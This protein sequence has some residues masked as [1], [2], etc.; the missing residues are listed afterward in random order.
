LFSSIAF[1]PPLQPPLGAGIA[2]GGMERKV[3]A[4]RSML[5]FAAFRDKD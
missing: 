5:V 4:K 1:L 2:L 3:C